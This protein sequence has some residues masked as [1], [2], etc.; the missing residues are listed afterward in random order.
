MKSLLRLKKYILLV[1]AIV[2]ANAIFSQNTI[3]INNTYGSLEDTVQVSVS[4]ANSDEFVSFQFDVFLPEGFSYVSGSAQLSSR[5]V[6]H[7]VSITHLD[8]NAIRVLS[9]SLNNTPFMLNEGSV[10]SFCLGT[11]TQKGD[12]LIELDNGIIGNHE[13][14]NILNSL[15][16]GVINLSPTSFEGNK[17]KNDGVICYPNPFSED[18]TVRILSD[19]FQQAD[20]QVFDLKG[21]LMST[22]QLELEEYQMN[23]FLFNSNELLGENPSEEIYLIHFIVSGSKHVV[24]KVQFQKTGL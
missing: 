9:Y 15:V 6:D 8:G 5:N 24:K 23:Q 1:V 13:S 17:E 16:G 2:M 3:Q 22:H 12:Y 19:H 21:V 14:E 7:V 10:V 11:P 20:M 4:I 18:L